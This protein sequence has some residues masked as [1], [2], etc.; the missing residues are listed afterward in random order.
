MHHDHAFRDAYLGG[1]EDSCGGPGRRQSHA[2]KPMD[3]GFSVEGEGDLLG[4]IVEE[5]CVGVV[6]KGDNGEG[7]DSPDVVRH[8][9]HLA[10]HN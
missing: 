6:E 1:S 8:L 4:E 9:H 2:L 10:A 5:V 7:L 3:D